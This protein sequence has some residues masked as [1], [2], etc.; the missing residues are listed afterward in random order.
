[1]Q[2]ENSCFAFSYASNRNA[3]K[4]RAAR[5][6]CMR[7]NGYTTLALG[8]HLDDVCESF[9]MSTFRNGFLRTM[10]ANYL[11]E[12]GDV[13]VIRPLVY[14]RE[15]TTEEL[16]RKSAVRAPALAVTTQASRYRARDHFG[17]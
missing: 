9:L 3:L 14:V 12:Q 17:C 10:K 5:Y 6:T 4:C 15:K 13:R 7:D 2:V 8:Q 16:A 1:M 11:V